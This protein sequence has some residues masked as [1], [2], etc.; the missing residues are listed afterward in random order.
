MTLRA[1][2]FFEAAFLTRPTAH[3]AFVIAF[4]AAA[5]GLP[6]TF[7][8]TQPFACGTVLEPRAVGRNQAK[9][10]RRNCAN[11]PS[12]GV[13]DGAEGWSGD[14]S[15]RPSGTG[16]RD[17]PAKADRSTDTVPPLIGWPAAGSVT[18]PL[19]VMYIP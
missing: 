11:I 4:L 18:W 13:S 16:T 8:I 9:L 3:W 6:L 2:T 14:M 5:S 1:R 10:A 15:R 19:G 17:Q 7:G 12:A